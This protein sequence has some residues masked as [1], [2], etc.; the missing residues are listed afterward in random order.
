MQFPYQQALILAIL[1]M[2]NGAPVAQ[3]QLGG[4][5]AAGGNIAN[6]ALNL[7]YV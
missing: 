4:V 3:P 6:S 7:A 2:A 1:G 5:A